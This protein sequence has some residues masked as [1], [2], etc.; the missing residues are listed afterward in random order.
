MSILVM[1]ASTPSMGGCCCVA[2]S[3]SSGATR[4]LLCCCILTTANHV[5][6]LIVDYASLC[7]AHMVFVKLIEHCAVFF[8]HRCRYPWIAR[9]YR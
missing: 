7:I 4:G 1:R 2:S 6:N 3:G 5:H 8:E 9:P